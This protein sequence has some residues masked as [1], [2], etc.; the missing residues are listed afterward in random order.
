MKGEIDE[1]TNLLG[2][3]RTPLSVIDKRSKQ[4]ISKDI[5]KLNINNQLDL[6]NIYRTI[7]TT[8]EY[9]LF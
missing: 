5:V 8:A 1:S 3:F 2:N 4:I 9:T 6:I 7:H